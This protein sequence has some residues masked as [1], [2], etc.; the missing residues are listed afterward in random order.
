MDTDV[1]APSTLAAETRALPS[2]SFAIPAIRKHWRALLSLHASIWG[3]FAVFAA[4]G[5]FVIVDWDIIDEMLRLD[6]ES[7]AA[8]TWEQ[9]SGPQTQIGEYF[10]AGEMF[11]GGWATGA[12]FI[13]FL[14][15]LFAACWVVTHMV[16]L[17]LV[18]F[19]RRLTAFEGFLLITPRLLAGLA[20][21][22][23]WLLLV[24][25]AIL[26]RFAP[27]VSSTD[28]R[29]GSWRILDVLGA[30]PFALG[31]TLVLAI[32]WIYLVPQVTLSDRPQTAFLTSIRL[33]WKAPGLT[34]GR[35]TGHLFL[36]ILASGVVGFVIWQLMATGLVTG[37]GTALVICVGVVAVSAGTTWVSLALF[38]LWQALHADEPLRREVPIVFAE[39]DEGIQFHAEQA[40]WNDE[41]HAG[42]GVDIYVPTV[43][44]GLITISDQDSSE[45]PIGDVVNE[46]L[47]PDLDLEEPSSIVLVPE[48]LA[49]DESSDEPS[50]TEMTSDDAWDDIMRPIGSVDHSQPL[51]VLAREADHT[52][53][54]EAE[55]ATPEVPVAPSEVD[56]TEETPSS[57]APLSKTHRKP[58]PR[59]PKRSSAKGKKE[60]V[61]KEEGNQPQT[62]N[63]PEADMTAADANGM[64]AEPVGTAQD[65]VPT[66]SRD[67]EAPSSDSE[68]AG[69]AE[70]SPQETQQDAT[71]PQENDK[72]VSNPTNDEPGGSATEHDSSAPD[73]PSIST[74]QEQSTATKRRKPPALPKRK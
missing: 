32:C 3:F 74:T 70:D 1:T 22:F 37:Y 52:G 16:S 56:E 51:P 18:S 53:R 50:E 58:P 4:G 41:S 44:G 68:L 63:E 61:A 60:T 36:W 49:Q 40:E 12:L 29:W 73:S 14:S 48:A 19:P 35:W 6:R 33:V 59:L 13:A 23:V 27:K 39:A 42:D 24:L 54:P 30:I 34:L 71:K 69:G 10:W 28:N 20:P 11:T 57:S 67:P 65:D 8:Q 55:G 7:A 2:F 72:E 17:R 26:L 43:D 21:Y 25:G 64:A 5:T 46:D 31:I 62:S 15:F 38:P 45:A 66:P 9:W 47:D